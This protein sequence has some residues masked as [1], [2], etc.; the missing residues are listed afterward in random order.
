[1]SFIDELKRRNVFR[2]GI[3]YVIVGWLL[4]QVAEFATEN[5]GA[6]EWVLK[7]FV[8]F[9]LLGFVLALFFSWVFEMTPE[10]IKLEKD[11]DRSQSIT[12]KTGRKLDF[13]IIAFLLL[14]LG[15]FAY[16]KFVLDPARDAALI[17]TVKV[18]EAESEATG[19]GDKS[20]AVLPFVNMSD[21]A[22][23]EY[24]S[25][26]IS[27]EI[28][29]ALARVQELKVAGRTSSFAFKGQIQDLRQIGNL[30]GVE[31]ILEGSVRKAG[32]KVRIT[33][34]LIRVENGFHLWSD[35]YDRELTDVFA[36]QDEI[37]SA[38]LEQLKAKLLGSEPVD[39]VAARTSSEAYDLYL[40]ARQRIYERA[41]L[42]IESAVSLLDEAITLDGEYA[43]AYAQRAIATLLL[44]DDSYG[45]IPQEQAESQ[46]RLYIDKALQLDPKQAEAWAALGLYHNSRIGE[47]GQAV[48]ALEKA[49][50]INPNLIN[51]QNWLHISHNQQG[52]PG[53][54]L[55]SVEKMV[56]MDPLYRPGIANAVLTYIDFG[57][58]DKALALLDRVEPF[59]PYDSNIMKGRARVHYSRGEFAAGLPLAETAL[60]QLPDQRTAK[61]AFAFG[62][63][64]TQQYEKAVGL[65][66]PFVEVRA[67]LNLGRKEE[68]MILAAN[69]ITDL[70]GATALFSA[71]NVLD[72]SEELV[73]Y[74]DERWDSLEALQREFP[75][76]AGTG[77]GLM[78]E[79]ALAYART[80]NETAFL[81]A[82]TR[83]R[84]VQDAMIEQGSKNAYLWLNEAVHYALAGDYTTSLLNL[85]RA[86]DGGLITS[87]RISFEH[88]ALEPIEGDP[89]FEALQARMVE[90]LNRERVKLG[91]EPVST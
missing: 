87:T 35:S 13:A 15:Y 56:E 90:H 65:G 69:S 61:A 67:L 26:G 30:L 52:N 32:D 9:L 38:I 80:G 49:I 40:L 48:Q 5:F 37:A 27:E 14:A 58:Q 53:A 51:A 73:S 31:H 54:A 24:F 45:V 41:R 22:G 47:G 88:P 57:L 75:P 28:L 23:N 12:I 18:E 91:L 29:N 63:Y 1:M 46:A 4:A 11:V 60:K 82:M 3:A 64:S 83:V 2:V 78:N 44:S 84:S 72:R 7:I 36:I 70:F 10:G 77:Y 81:D 55:R 43:P 50:S 16:D 21:D 8:V 85:T 33:A 76:F 89:Q 17:E 25:D 42:S 39:V 62:L 71:L 20:I 68:A 86:I 34:Q 59:M 6:P 74:I 66:V 79:V 19:L